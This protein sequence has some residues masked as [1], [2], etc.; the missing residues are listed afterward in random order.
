MSD[1]DLKPDTGRR[2]R[3]VMEGD[4]ERTRFH[5]AQSA[6]PLEIDD[7]ATPPPQ[8]PPDP[9]S[10]DGFDALAPELQRQLIAFWNTQREQDVA[11]VR[12]WES[13]NV[14]D[15]VLV[16]RETIVAISGRL[17]QL[18]SIPAQLSQQ[19]AAMTQLL[20]WKDA[21][22]KLD[23]RLER[24]LDHLDK[25]LDHVERDDVKRDGQIAMVTRD[26]AASSALVAKGFA[27]LQKTIDE[28]NARVRS[29]EEDRIRYKAKA[30]GVAATV[31]IFV[32]ILTWLLA[33]VWK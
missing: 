26:L 17:D 10:L 29:L 32:A 6:T 9:S 25:R 24:T 11:L 30:A 16:L 13:R 2:P 4:V 8:E 33:R 21:R 12:L 5:R 19:R 27:E 20:A 23:D 28:L 1:R 31:S 7:E 15:D 14:K 22:T 3:I 18:A